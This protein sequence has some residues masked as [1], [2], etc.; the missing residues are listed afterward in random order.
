[1][2]GNI[3]QLY[4]DGELVGER[5]VLDNRLGLAILR[6]LDRLAETGIA[7]STI[8]QHVTLKYKPR[9]TPACNP[10][11]IDWE[12]AI[13]ALRTGDDEGVA[14]AL[15]LIDGDK[16]QEVEGPPNPS[17]QSNDEDEGLDLFDRCWK[18]GIEDV[19]MTD[20][21]PPPGFT[22]YE[23]RPYDEFHEDEPYVRACTDE[24][25]AILDA[26]RAADR[27][28]VREEEAELRDRWFDLLKSELTGRGITR[29]SC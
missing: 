11:A 1:M 29:L 16:V 17:S 15:A 3:E 6:R 7:V 19:W 13:D 21:P 27:A 10:Q 28:A 4:K 26:D 20:F 2:E 9:P 25:A 5:H 23:S 18:D 14:K 24:E 8:G 22:G 12:L